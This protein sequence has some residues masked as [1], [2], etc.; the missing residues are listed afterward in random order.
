MLISG[1]SGRHICVEM[2]SKYLSHITSMFYSLILLRKAKLAFPKRTPER[3]RTGEAGLKTLFHSE[4]KSPTRVVHRC[5]PEEAV[6]SEPSSP[7]P[8]TISRM[9]GPASWA[10]RTT[11]MGDVIGTESGDCMIT[12]V[13]EWRVEPDSPIVMMRCR[14]RIEKRKR[15]LPPPLTLMREMGEMPWAFTRECNGDGRLIIT[16]ERVSRGHD[17]H[18][19]CIMEV[20][21]EGERVTMRLVPED[22]DCCE[23]CGYPIVDDDDGEMQ[24]NDG[25]EI[26]E[27]LRKSLEFEE[28]LAKKVSR[29]S[30]RCGDLR[31]CVSLNFY[32]SGP[33]WLL[34][35]HLS[36]SFPDIYL[37]R[38]AS[39]PIRPMIPSR[40]LCGQFLSGAAAFVEKPCEAANRSLTFV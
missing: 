33:D 5:T 21:T 15:Q 11:L 16:A 7:A 17:G 30:E 39:A 40:R 6:E 31:D 23:L 35:P 37:G 38:P 24:F 28:E 26:E 4:L 20:R 29:E 12:Y 8:P 10:F 1:N 36:D 14:E 9:W 27:S 13:E 25:F 34:Q 19:H 2:L 22:D 32:A 3:R 18:E